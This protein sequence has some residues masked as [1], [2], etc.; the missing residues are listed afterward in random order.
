[1]DIVDSETFKTVQTFD[2]AQC[3]SFVT[4]KIETVRFQHNSNDRFVIGSG[5]TVQMWSTNKQKSAC[6]L[7][8]TGLEICGQSVDLYGDTLAVGGKY[9]AACPDTGI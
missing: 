6:F 8:E 7:V 4:Q 9:G 5:S 1:M 2:T 3:D